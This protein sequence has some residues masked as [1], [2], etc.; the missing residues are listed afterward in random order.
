[1][2]WCLEVSLE[3]KS[4]FGNSVF[5]KAALIFQQENTSHGAAVFRKSEIQ[6]INRTSVCWMYSSH[7][8]SIC[9]SYDCVTCQLVCLQM[10]ESALPKLI[11][12]MKVEWTR[13]QK[14]MRGGREV[15]D[16]LS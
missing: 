10:R 3:V 6:K 14:E 11:R 5:T 15:K 16:C 2:L 4:L 12:K 8:C 9:H 13:K 7:I 1:M